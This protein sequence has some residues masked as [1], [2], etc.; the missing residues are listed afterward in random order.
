MEAAVKEGIRDGL[1]HERWLREMPAKRYIVHLTEDERTELLGLITKGITSARLLT[2]AR[3]LLKADEGWKDKEIDQALNSHVATIERIRQ[4]F[5]EVNLEK[6]LHDD[7]RPGAKC[8]LDGRAEAQRIALACSKAPEGH[9][10]W[11][12]RLLAGTLVELGVVESVSY[13]TVRQRLKKTTS[14]LGSAKRGAYPNLARSSWL[15][16]KTSWMCMKCPTTPLIQP[17]AWMRNPSN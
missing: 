3:R 12:M 10:A 9:A 2:R 15:R 7:P 17:S 5:V 4:R 11:S 13:E 1:D 8:K 16:W 14:S 6:A